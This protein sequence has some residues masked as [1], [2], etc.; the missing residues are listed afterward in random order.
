[1]KLCMQLKPELLFESHLT[2]ESQLTEF[3]SEIKPHLGKHS[4]LL[5]SG[6]LAAGKTT[7]T[8]Y[9]CGLYN[10]KSIQSPTYSI[11][12]R[13][14]NELIA[15]DHFDLYRMQSEDDLV[16]TGFWDF[17]REEKS[18]VIVEWFEKIHD[19]TW[20]EV[21]SHKRNIFAVKIEVL[22]DKRHFKFFKLI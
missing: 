17:L 6:D 18:L 19:N 5:L 7:F 13:Y 15:I 16:S 9:L 8:R 11:H 2:A 1:M 21:E 14:Q 3:V 10:L 20:L 22:D 4:L 12:Q